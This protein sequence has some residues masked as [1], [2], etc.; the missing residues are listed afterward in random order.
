MWD[1]AKA[2]L[3]GKLIAPNVYTRKEER[4]KTNHLSSC[5]KKLE[6]QMSKLNPKE[7]EEK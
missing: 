4:S 2:V 3:R 6:K 7:V 5:V 1:S